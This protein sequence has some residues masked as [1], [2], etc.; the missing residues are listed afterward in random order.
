[1]LYCLCNFIGTT[2]GGITMEQNF[3]EKVSAFSELAFAKQRADT[4]KLVAD[5]K[6]RRLNRLLAY[7]IA[8]TLFE[9]AQ[10]QILDSLKQTILN[11]SSPYSGSFSVKLPDDEHINVD[12]GSLRQ[13]LSR[14]VT[15]VIDSWLDEH[16]LPLFIEKVE[17]TLSTRQR[18]WSDHEG[19]G[20]YS[21]GYVDIGFSTKAEVYLSAFPK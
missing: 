13:E 11:L 5:A 9:E 8:A 17:V 2:K 15:H 6:A 16:D 20:Q 14:L 18:Y 1:M 19:G 3:F 7:H 21:D 4:E 10:T 12:Y